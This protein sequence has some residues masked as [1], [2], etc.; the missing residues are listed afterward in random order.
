METEFLHQVEERKDEEIL[1]KA[2]E[3]LEIMSSSSEEEIEEQQITIQDTGVQLEDFTAGG[4]DE[5]M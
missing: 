5:I 2:R 4:Q 1:K 3:N